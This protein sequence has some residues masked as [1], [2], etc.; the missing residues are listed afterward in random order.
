MLYTIAIFIHTYHNNITKPKTREKKSWK[1]T[2]KMGNAGLASHCFSWL[3][4]SL[5]KAFLLHLCVRWQS[6]MTKR[7]MKW[8]SR[9][10]RDESALSDD[11]HR[12]MTSETSSTILI[13]RK[14]IAHSLSP[15]RTSGWMTKIYHH[16]PCCV[17]VDERKMLLHHLH[18]AFKSVVAI[19]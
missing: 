12:S 14:D 16:W 7:P 6:A 18:F 1:E 8:I 4:L 17:H 11:E 15:N 3:S 9:S 5:Y 10:Y 13:I 19:M 2:K